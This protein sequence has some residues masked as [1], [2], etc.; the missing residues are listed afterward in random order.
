MQ[1]SRLRGQ[2]KL[3]HLVLHRRPLLAAHAVVVARQLVA[4]ALA[5]ADVVV[6]AA[7]A[8]LL[9]E[10]RGAGVY[11]A[12]GWLGVLYGGGELGMDACGERAR[13]SARRCMCLLV[14]MR[15]RRWR[16]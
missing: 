4:V 13:T 12:G 9:V 10:L 14:W 11:D 3:R 7:R 15:R 16:R 5:Q 1:N 6:A 8:D 2:A